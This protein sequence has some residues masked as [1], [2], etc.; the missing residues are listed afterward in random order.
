[1]AAKTIPLEF[2]LASDTAKVS[3]REMEIPSQL[4][5][6]GGK[7]IAAMYQ[8]PGG[9]RVIDVFGKVPPDRISWQGIILGPNSFERATELDDMRGRNP[10][11]LTYGPSSW[12]GVLQDFSPVPGFE[13]FIPYTAVF[14]PAAQ[15]G[16]PLGLDLSTPSL[17][18]SA[19]AAI[20]ACNAAVA[21]AQAAQSAQVPEAAALLMSAAVAAQGAVVQFG[22]SLTLANLQSASAVG[23]AAR[24]LAAA[25]ATAKTLLGIPTLSAADMTL[26]INLFVAAATAAG[27][28]AQKPAAT[29]ATIVVQDPNLYQLAVTYYGDPDLWTKIAQVNGLQ[30]PILTGRYDLLIP[31]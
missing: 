27:L 4:T 23:G 15:K 7:A 24:L 26:S 13:G 30:Q 14:L 8:F 2:S 28:Y 20:A 25:A 9:R 31:Q 5:S 16:L 18:V 3:F 1:M 10:A 6:L 21:A 12:T 11:T 22:N 17:D 29:Q 19:Q